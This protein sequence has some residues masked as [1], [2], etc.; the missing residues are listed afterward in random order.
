MDYAD[1]VPPDPP[2]ATCRVDLQRENGDAAW[3]FQIVRGQVITRF[4]GQTD[5]VVGLNHLAVWAAI[6]AYGVQDRTGTF[7][8]VMALFY[9]RLNEERDSE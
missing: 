7:E 6:D 8:K 2:C 9:S 5:M 1:K 4:N 3:I